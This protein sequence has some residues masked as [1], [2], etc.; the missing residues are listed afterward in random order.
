MA[1]AA[2]SDVLVLRA[3]AAWR[4]KAQT[5]P[6]E[7]GSRPPAASDAP[8]GLGVRAIEGSVAGLGRAPSWA[9]RRC[10]RAH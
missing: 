5:Q 4:G 6:W 8:P 10:V 2:A 7:F 3:A 1:A 9:P